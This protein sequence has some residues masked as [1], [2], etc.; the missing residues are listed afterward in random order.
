MVVQGI[1]THLVLSK[2]IAML[3]QFAAGLEILDVLHAV[4]AKPAIFESLFVA[5]AKR[6]SPD[7]VK[8]LFR[9][10]PSEYT[11]VVTIFNMVK[12]YI[13]N[14]SEEGK[15]LN[16]AFKVPA[17]AN[18]GHFYCKKLSTHCL[19]IVQRSSEY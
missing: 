12:K 3:D 6:I 10:K 17:Q 11:E 13:E 5:S 7:S 2:R 14:S 8:S 15:I 4:R 16:D 9:L 1:I 19:L 18:L